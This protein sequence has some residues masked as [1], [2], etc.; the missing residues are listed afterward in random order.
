M[1]ATD[2]GRIGPT[3]HE[4]NG[5]AGVDGLSRFIHQ[6]L[7]VLEQPV[8]NPTASSQT[9]TVALTCGTTDL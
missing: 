4:L 8:S 5:V 1:I 2:A 6:L 3:N 7:V 9:A